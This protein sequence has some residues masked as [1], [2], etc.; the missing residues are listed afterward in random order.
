MSPLHHQPKI[1]M[2]TGYGDEEAHKQVVEEGLDGCLT[3]PVT[4]RSLFDAVV[5]AFE[6]DSRTE[7]AG[8][9]VNE[10]AGDKRRY[11]QLRGMRVLLVED[12]DMETNRGL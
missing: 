5:A 8:S 3:R 10:T 1:I 2:I 11:G 7:P 4:L 12:N 9:P 6:S